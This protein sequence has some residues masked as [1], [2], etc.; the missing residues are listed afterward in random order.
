MDWGG[1]FTAGTCR[2]FYYC[3]CFVAPLGTDVIDDHLLWVHVSYCSAIH[4]SNE[5]V[6]CGGLF[7][8]L[9]LAACGTLP[10]LWLLKQGWWWDVCGLVLLELWHF[11]HQWPFFPQPLHAESRAG[12]LCLPGGCWQV[13]LGHGAYEHLKLGIMCL[14]GVAYSMYC[15]TNTHGSCS[16][17]TA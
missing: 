10:F 3:V 14:V 4:R 11:A 1:T 9:A 16:W 17:F 5:Q 2:Q 15:M 12:Q 6:L 13:Q 8:V 7:S